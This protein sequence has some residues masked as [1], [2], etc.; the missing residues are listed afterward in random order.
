MLNVKIK[1]NIKL[2]NVLMDMFLLNMELVLT[3]DKIVFH[4]EGL[5]IQLNNVQLL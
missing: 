3:I 5:Q 2:L 4:V 1:I